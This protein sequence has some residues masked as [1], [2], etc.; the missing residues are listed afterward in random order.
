LEIIDEYLRQQL[1]RNWN[2]YLDVL[3]IGA[4]DRVIDLGSSVGAVADMLAK[5]VAWVTGIDSNSDFVNYSLAR[6]KSNQSFICSDFTQINYSELKPVTGIW[7]SFSIAYVSRP[8]EYLAQL[9]EILE[10]GGWLALVEVSGFI[11]GNMLPESKYL[12]LVQKFENQSYKSGVYDF[13]LGAKLQTIL[14]EIGFKNIYV[15][16][17][18]TDVELNFN[19]AANAEILRNWQARLAR[20][21]GL[22]SSYPAEYSDICAEVIASLQ[23]KQH[24]KNQN[25]CYLVARK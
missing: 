22:R 5:K 7:A 17:D 8:A 24:R 9:Y 25:V 2:Q 6:A 20:M 18:V 12:S 19:G 4:N 1:W 23:S 13:K 14:A 10:P 21:Q 11:S 3:P 15:D 16:N